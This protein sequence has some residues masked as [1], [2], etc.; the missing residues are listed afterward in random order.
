MS[1][2]NIEFTLAQKACNGDVN[3]L[4]QLYSADLIIY[5]ERFIYTLTKCDSF[6]DEDREDIVQKTLET[7]MR[8][9]SSFNGESR[10]STFVIGFAKNVV[11]KQRD[12]SAK[13]RRRELSLDQYEEQFSSLLDDATGSE[14]Y[15]YDPL[16]I[17]LKKEEKEEIV[18]ALR[19]LTKEEQVL[20]MMREV[21]R[22][23]V[24][25]IATR[26]NC[27]EDAVSSRIRRILNKLRSF[28]NK[29][30]DFGAKRD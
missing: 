30:T 16:K 12:L 8:K 18:R 22:I 27:S 29:P 6:S 20:L 13:T 2:V 25:E 11:F 5:L 7:S 19:S 24:K 23:R 14:N 1:V 15:C 3:A 21:D 17:L 4:Q 10:F 28:L 26:M 9:L